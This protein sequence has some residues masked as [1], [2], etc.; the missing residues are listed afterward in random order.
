MS[1]LQV[2]HLQIAVGLG[3]VIAFMHP[4]ASA[5]EAALKLK[6]APGRDVVSAY[7]SICHSLD[8]IPMNAPVMTPSRWEGSVRKM[9][10]KMGAPIDSTNAEKIV[11]YLST[12]YAQA[13]P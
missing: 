10:D 12:Q 8:Y 7:C 2:A 4:V 9:I 1:R 13:P 6:E 11:Q 3:F 5:N